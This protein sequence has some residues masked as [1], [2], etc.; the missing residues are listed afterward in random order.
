[1]LTYYDVACANKS[2]ANKTMTTDISERYKIEWR[3]SASSYT[4]IDKDE[5]TYKTITRHDDSVNHVFPLKFTDSAFMSVGSDHKIVINACSGKE[6]LSLSGHIENVLGLIEIDEERLLSAGEDKTIRVWSLDTGESLTVIE[7]DANDI[8]QITISSCHNFIILTQKKSAII[9]SI[10]GKKLVELKGLRTRIKAFT[11]LSSG[12]W[13]IQSQ[14]NSI[15]LWS[16]RGKLLTTFKK[17]FELYNVI[18]KSQGSLLIKE[19][20]GTISFWSKKGKLVKRHN[21][22]ESVSKTFQSLIDGIQKKHQH[23]TSHSHIRHYPHSKNSLYDRDLSF[24]NAAKQIKKQK[25]NF[26]NNSAQR[27]TWDFFNRPVLKSIK[28]ALKSVISRARQSETTL[29]EKRQ[30]NLVHIKKR[31]IHLIY[32]SLAFALLTSTALLSVNTTYQAV[33]NPEGFILE[34]SNL[35]GKLPKSIDFLDTQIPQ[36]LMVRTLAIIVVL[37][38]IFSAIKLLSLSRNFIK[39][40]QQ[41]RANNVVIKEAFPVIEELISQIKSH[42]RKILTESPSLHNIDLYK[43]VHIT[44]KI[45]KTIHEKLKKIALNECGL[46]QGDIIF[47]NQEPIILSGWSLIQD[48]EKRKEVSNQLSM[49]NE[50]SFWN[51][52]GQLTFAVQYIQYIFLTK[53]KIDVFTSYYDFIKDRIYGKESNAFYYKDV[54]NMHKKDVQRTSLDLNQNGESF[55]ATEIALFVASGEK[56]Q[57]TI[58]NEESLASIEKLKNDK[59]EK[60]LQ[61]VIDELIEERTLLMNNSQISN[62]TRQEECDLID[63]Q[64]TELEMAIIQPNIELAQ[65]KADEAISNIRKQ[66]KSNKLV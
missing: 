40:I 37:L 55:A 30:E 17:N 49:H 42:R 63:S 48:E 56:I 1:M 21:R 3:T 52:H 60:P 38:A 36:D 28:T 46:S 44:S 62:T 34:N 33:K 6:L 12:N 10:N 26:E 53:D 57:L 29:E 47:K 32:S 23:I 54:T 59:K 43:G 41:C 64:I 27:K 65:S 4:I 14:K 15:S 20:D 24:F 13:L 19:N 22:S 45:Q 35:T 8:N 50:L 66:V 58:L 11:S 61:E 39:D 18:E 51:I 9:W 16:E 2:S 5:D 25:L 31:H 7:G